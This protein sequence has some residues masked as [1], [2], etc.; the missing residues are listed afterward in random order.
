MKNWLEK[1]R[2]NKT[3]VWLLALALCAAALFLFPAAQPQAGGMTEEEKRLSATL[4]Q[5]AGAGRVRLSIYYGQAPSAFG[6]GKQAPVGAVIVARGA[7]KTEVRLALLHA[8]ETLLG[9]DAQ[10]VE[11]FPMEDA[12]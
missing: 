2:G 11:V 8:A 1:I 9:L 12:P 7:E 3:G 10:R 5:I 6:G 4:S